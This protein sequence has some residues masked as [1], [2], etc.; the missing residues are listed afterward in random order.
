MSFGRRRWRRLL[1]AKIFKIFSFPRTKRLT[2]FRF[3][4]ISSKSCSSGSTNDTDSASDKGV[5]GGSTAVG[6]F[7]T[8]LFGRGGRPGFDFSR[9]FVVVAVVVRKGEAFSNTASIFSMAVS[10]LCPVLVSSSTVLSI[11]FISSSIAVPFA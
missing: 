4:T 2:R 10:L 5:A 8:L 6:V 9:F 11:G 7:G 1:A 3:R